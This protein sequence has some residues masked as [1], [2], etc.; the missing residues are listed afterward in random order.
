MINGE[1]GCMIR[2]LARQGLRITDM[3][4][5]V[6]GDGKTV[7]SDLADPEPPRY[8]ARPPRVSKLAPCKASGQQR[9]ECGVYHGEVLYREWCAR[10][11]DGKKT[12]LRAS[13][14]PRRRA[15]R[16]PACGRFETPP[17]QQGQVDWGH[18]GTIWH[19][20]SHRRL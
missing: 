2:E 16:P 3:A 14:P 4:P 20:G 1:E 9:L 18:W 10:G 11:D 7:R 6:G 19:A 13:V 17:G 5:R 8:T 15:A 12:R